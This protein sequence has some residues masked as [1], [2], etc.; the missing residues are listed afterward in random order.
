MILL[1][2]VCLTLP[3]VLEMYRNYFPPG[4]LLEIYKSHG[5][6]LA[7]FD[8]LSLMCPTVTGVNPA[9]DAGDTSPPIFWL[10]GRQQEYPRQYY[11]VLLDI[12]DQYWLPSVR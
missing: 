6:C 4:N 9:G 7:Q 1:K 2:P 3:E 10:G 12:T 11:Y 5:N 8:H